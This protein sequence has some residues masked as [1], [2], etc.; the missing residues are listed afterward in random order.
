VFCL[1]PQ[2]LLGK[3]EAMTSPPLAG[4]TN[5]RLGKLGTI[6][7]LWVLCVIGALLV[8]QLASLNEGV[9]KQNQALAQHNEL[10]VALV[11]STRDLSMTV[12]NIQPPKQQDLP[13][14]TNLLG[15]LMVEVRKLREAIEK[16]K[17]KQE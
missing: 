14:Y 17:G 9:Q 13:N 11:N 4:Q 3:G 12:A 10:Q 16:Q 2:P 1:G 6:L 5:D 15:A 7:P 8:W